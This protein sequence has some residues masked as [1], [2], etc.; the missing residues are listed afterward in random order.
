MYPLLLKPPIKDY[1]WGGTKLK[2]DFIQTKIR[3]LTRTDFRLGSLNL[4]A[5]MKCA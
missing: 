1:L 3:P 5:R 2:A 4:M